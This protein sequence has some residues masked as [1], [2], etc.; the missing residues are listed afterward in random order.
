MKL[1]TLIAALASAA[2]P[3]FADEHCALVG[4]VAAKVMEFRQTEAPMSQAI[5]LIAAPNEDTTIRETVRL[6]I[7]EAYS[8]PAFQTEE[9]RKQS[10][11]QFRNDV[12]LECYLAEG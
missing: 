1:L 11:D 7:M 5:E 10:I 4:R 3:V 2:G 9:N 6:M 12:E 8:R